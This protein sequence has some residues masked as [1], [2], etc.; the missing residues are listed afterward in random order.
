V[1]Y[2]LSLVVTP[3]TVTC[4]SWAPSCGD[5]LFTCGAIPGR[6]TASFGNQKLW[7]NCKKVLSLIW[8]GNHFALNLLSW[9]CLNT[10]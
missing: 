3:I 2:D 7:R 8:W 9:V 5:H 10:I 6:H 1:N 4:C